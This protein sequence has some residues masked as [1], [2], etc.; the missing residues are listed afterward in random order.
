MAIAQSIAIHWNSSFVNLTWLAL[1]C[2][3]LEPYTKCTGSYGRLQDQ[4]AGRQKTGKIQIY[5]RY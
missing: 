1:L 4:P 3:N 5:K 2:K